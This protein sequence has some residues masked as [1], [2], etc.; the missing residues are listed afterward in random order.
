MRGKIQLPAAIMVFES[1][2][3]YCAKQPIFN[4][5]NLLSHAG[6]KSKKS[7][8]DDQQVGLNVL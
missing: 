4:I 7:S 6:S 1:V 8:S 2:T 3:E 5:F